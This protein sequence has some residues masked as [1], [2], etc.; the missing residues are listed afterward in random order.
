MMIMHQEKRKNS[1]SKHDNIYEGS[2]EQRFMQALAKCRT[3]KHVKMAH[4]FLKSRKDT[5]IDS[6]LSRAGK[7][8]QCSCIQYVPADNLAYLEWRNEQKQIP[9]KK[10]R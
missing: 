8:Q 3:C 4:S 10:K 2:E 5:C 9:V 6:I 7:Q 1:M